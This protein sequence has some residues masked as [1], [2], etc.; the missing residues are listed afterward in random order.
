MDLA[1]TKFVKIDGTSVEVAVNSADEAR[2]AVK[3]LR[4]KKKEIVHRR[5][6]LLR[7]KRVAEAIAERGRPKS[8]RVK[9]KGWWDRISSGAATLWALA[10]AYGR[11]SK[12]MDVSQIT[13]DCSRLDE[14]AHNLDACLL[15]IEGKLL[16]ER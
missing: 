14:L 3:E 13:R 9:P 4:H 12:M 1:P 10:F 5:R 11:A 8:R 16:Q 15:K 6:A 2:L 7:Q